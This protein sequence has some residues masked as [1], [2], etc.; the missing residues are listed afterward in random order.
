VPC[1][2]LPQNLAVD[3]SAAATTTASS[4]AGIASDSG[5]GNLKVSVSTE[6]GA[7]AVYREGEKMVVLVTVNKAAYLKVFH[8]DASGVVRLI[9]PNKFSPGLK[10]AQPGAVIR[11]PDENDAFSFDM[12]PPFGT[13]FIKVVASTS[14]FAEDE[15]R[16]SKGDSF[17]E[18]GTDVR[19][20]LT[21]GIKVNAVPGKDERAEAMAS[22][23]ITQH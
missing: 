8:V 21:R 11:I 7:G 4:L 15:N 12:T 18:L 16:L 1:S 3:P 17:A 20:A 13:E 5:K 14:P 19:G 2:S 10:L 6:R 9:L 23:V 22:Y